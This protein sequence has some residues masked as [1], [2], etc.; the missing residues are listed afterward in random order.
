[1]RA[2]LLVPTFA[3]F[4]AFAAPPARC[5]TRIA[6]IVANTD[7]RGAPLA[8]PTIDADLV[9]SALEKMGFDVTVAKDAGL[10]AF[11][12]ALSNF[13]T[14]SRGSDIAIFYFAGHGFAVND[15]LEAR[16]YLMSTSAD[17]TST[18]ERVYAPAGLRLTR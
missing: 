7:Y 14:R 12:E 2:F 3:L 13:E 5:D 15:G 6:L 9:S 16:N 10:A 18:S 11:D 17:V 4:F 1:M 8:N